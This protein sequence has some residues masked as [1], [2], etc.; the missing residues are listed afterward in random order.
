MPFGVQVTVADAAPVPL[1]PAVWLF[2]SGMLGFGAL[3]RRRRPA[4]V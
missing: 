3:V 1:P 2:G 4:I